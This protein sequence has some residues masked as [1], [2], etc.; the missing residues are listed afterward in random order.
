MVLSQLNISQE[1]WHERIVRHCIYVL[2]NC[3][4]LRLTKLCNFRFHW[5]CYWPNYNILYQ[6][7]FNVFVNFGSNVPA[8]SH[9]T[10]QRQYVV[11]WGT[12]R[13]RNWSAFG[14]PMFNQTVE[15]TWTAKHDCSRSNAHVRAHFLFF[16]VVCECKSPCT[17]FQF[18]M[19]C[20]DII[21]CNPLQSM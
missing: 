20:S 9:M 1:A 18:W 6:F 21:Q 14:P 4:I 7:P 5:P 2:P 16:C 17:L 13:F 19:V 10:S 11:A 8:L 12:W 15:H 3:A